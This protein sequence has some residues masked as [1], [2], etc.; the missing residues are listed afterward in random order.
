MIQEA[1]RV[2][3]WEDNGLK[4]CSIRGISENHY[5]SA[6]GTDQV[7]RLISSSCIVNLP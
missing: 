4:V 3:S 2:D 6:V 7:V 1:C 5:F